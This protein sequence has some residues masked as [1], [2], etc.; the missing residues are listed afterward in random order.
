MQYAFS[1]GERHH[2]CYATQDTDKD[3]G[4]EM[5]IKTFVITEGTRQ[6]V[7]GCTIMV[8]R[9]LRQPMQYGTDVGLA[10]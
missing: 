2:E 8:L 10:T 9:L 7:Y 1:Q 5:A 4:R 3:D 6:D